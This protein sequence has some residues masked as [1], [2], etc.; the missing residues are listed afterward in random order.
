M[1]K[2][3]SNKLKLNRETLRKIDAQRAVRG[4][5]ACSAGRIAQGAPLAEPSFPPMHCCLAMW[6]EMI[7]P[8][9]A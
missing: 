2:Y 1:K 9:R 5:G 4:G 8:R 6:G 3:R 7:V